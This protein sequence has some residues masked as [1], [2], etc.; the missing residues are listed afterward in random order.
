[1]LWGDFKDNALIDNPGEEPTS[2][3][4]SIQYQVV[5]TP[6][7]SIHNPPDHL[8][9]PS[10]GN[11]THQSTS[12]ASTGVHTTAGS[13]SITHRPTPAVTQKYLELCVNS[14][15]YDISLVEINL[16]TTSAPIITDGQLFCEIRKRY[17]ETRSNLVL[18]KLRFFRPAFLSYVRVCPPISRLPTTSISSSSYC[19]HSSASPT[20]PSASFPALSPSPPPPPATSSP[21]VQ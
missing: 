19:V 4:S 2:H 3:P 5:S 10:T 15:E 18:H 8:L 7:L 6:W 13:T 21:R 17:N 1:M 11:I 20:P 14:S 9:R 16:S 12:G